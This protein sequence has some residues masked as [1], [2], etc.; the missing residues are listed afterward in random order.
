[1]ERK[2][3]IIWIK[4]SQKETFS[5][6][7]H[8]GASY[9]DLV[10]RLASRNNVFFAYDASS[11]QGNDLFFPV[12]E[13]KN[14]ELIVSGNGE[15]KI[16]ADVIYNLGNIPGDDFIV[17]DAK[18]TNTPVFK[19]FFASKFDAYTLL[20]AFFPKTIFIDNEAAFSEEIKNIVGE[21]IVFKPNTGTGGRDVRI[22]NRADAVLDEEMKKIILQGA[23]LQEF[24][25]TSRGIP[26][27]CD[28]Y[29]D[30]R[31]AT[32]N[33]TIALTHVRTP[34][35]GS[36]IANYQQGATIREL[37]RE[38]LPP[39]VISFHAK[40]H[41]IIARKFPHPM[42]TMDIGLNSQGQ[43]Q[44]FEINSTTAFPWPEFESKD[45]FIEQLAAHV[46][47]LL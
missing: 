9:K 10:V 41:A 42:Y 7:Y 47:S 18:I 6:L 24:I 30:L 37:A 19:K 21:P 45:F 46:E 17:R 28:S 2:N 44:L 16:K 39:V 29:H 26:G 33:D 35:P 4:S 43:P 22:F 1:M 40:V 27:I 25:D 5:S 13:Y 20:S 8:K 32:V 23:L 3:I 38:D 11:Y 12:S 14:G 34:A 31:L 36:L 15:K